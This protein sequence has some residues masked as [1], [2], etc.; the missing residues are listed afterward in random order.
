MRP[1][2]RNLWL[3]L[4][5]GAAAAAWAGR[6]NASG[7]GRMVLDGRVVD[8]AGHPVRAFVTGTLEWDDGSSTFRI[9][10]AEVG[11]A[12]RFDLRLEPAASHLRALRVTAS[13][14]G[15]STST[16]IRTVPRGEPGYR[17]IVLRLRPAARLT[18]RV[19]DAAGAPVRGATVVL[20][21]ASAPLAPGAGAARTVDAAGQVRYA[22]LD[23]R[24]H[25]ELRVAGPG[26]FLPQTIRPTT[27]TAP[28]PVV[29][30]RGAD[31]R[32]LLVDAG[33]HRPVAGCRLLTRAG[34]VTTDRLGRFIVPGAPYGQVAIWPRCAAYGTD[35]DGARSGLVVNHTAANAARV[36]R[37]S[38]RHNQLI[39]GRVTDGAGRPLPGATVSLMPRHD[40]AE[41]RI[42][43]PP[44][45]AHHHRRAWTVPLQ[46]LLERPV[47]DLRR[48]RE[49]HVPGAGDPAPAPSPRHAAQ[50]HSAEPSPVTG[51]NHSCAA[52]IA[53]AATPRHRDSGDTASSQQREP[54]VRS[55]TRPHSRGRVISARHRRFPSYHPDRLL[56]A[57][58]LRLHV[59]PSPGVAQGSS[60]QRTLPLP[61]RERAA[62]DRYLED[63]ALALDL[64]PPGAEPE[65]VVLVP[66]DDEQDDDPYGMAGFLAA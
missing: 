48:P 12:G 25:L 30:V 52:V 51:A 42:W 22:G 31:L 21:P 8:S 24:A 46:Q 53:T 9:E 26:D 23:D 57:S 17:P 10:P 27:L 66:L 36:H 7:T 50:A 33:T 40:P 32:G 65:D 6:A 55:G 56:M 59:L 60:G 3:A 45:R 18:V 5:L 35:Y 63:L 62:L 61:P 34:P 28:V 44:I 39:A 37:L 1:R 58:T 15:Y 19:I 54:R 13:A 47:R 11:P 43:D 4:C 14:R 16:E 38:A 29:L 64:E 2:A 41:L 49:R 20:D